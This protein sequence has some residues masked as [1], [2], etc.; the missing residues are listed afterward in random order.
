M[1]TY[2]KYSEWSKYTFNIDKWYLHLLATPGVLKNLLMKQ[3][4]I[5]KYS[6]LRIKYWTYTNQNINLMSYHTASKIITKHNY[7]KIILK[8][9]FLPKIKR[10]ISKGI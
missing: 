2:Y 10:Y 3:V 9:M 1:H 6:I 7:T 4:I 8:G 5:T